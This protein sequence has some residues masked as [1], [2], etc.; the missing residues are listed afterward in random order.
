[1]Y[2][3]YYFPPLIRC[4]YSSISSSA[5]TS[6]LPQPHP[7]SI[8]ALESSNAI[9]ELLGTMQEAHTLIIF[10]LH[11]IVCST[12]PNTIHTVPIPSFLTRDVTK[13]SNMC[14]CPIGLCNGF[15]NKNNKYTIQTKITTRHFKQKITSSHN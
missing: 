3:N 14:V 2:L 6:L 13:Y 12:C 15:L 10:F 8:V 1:M 5:T 7:S 11:V 4:G 9:F